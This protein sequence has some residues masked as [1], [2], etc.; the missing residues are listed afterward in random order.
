MS[1]KITSLLVVLTVVLFTL[2]T[3]AQTTFKAQ[4]AKA[5]SVQVLKGKKALKAADQQKAK[6][7]IAFEVEKAQKAAEAAQAEALAATPQATIEQ[8]VNITDGFTP[9]QWYQNATKWANPQ[10]AILKGAGIQ[11]AQGKPFHATHKVNPLEGRSLAE[12]IAGPKKAA[13][14]DEHGIITAPDEGETKYYSRAG[15]AY[16][17]SSNQVY[18]T[19]QS[20]T[21]QIVRGR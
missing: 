12:K 18:Y 21:V 9:A 11:S 3:Q 2:P 5:G 14:E 4:K 15:M 17:L 8:R 6:A 20:G 1:K 7:A 16:Y 19:E 13:T 10:S